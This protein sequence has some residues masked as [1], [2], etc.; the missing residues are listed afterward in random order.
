MRDTRL[1][2]GGSKC[3]R[4]LDKN[5]TDVNADTEPPAAALKVGPNAGKCDASAR[6]RQVSSCARIQAT[7]QSFSCVKGT[8]WERL[9]GDLTLGGFKCDCIH[10]CLEASDRQR[11]LD[12]FRRGTVP[13]LITTDFESR[14]LDVED[15]THVFNYD[16]PLNIGKYLHRVQRA[17]RA[18]RRGFS[19]TLVSR[20]EWMQTR[21]LIEVLEEANQY[22]PQELYAMADHFD[23][24]KKR[25][26]KETSTDCRR[27][28]SSDGD[29]WRK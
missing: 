9:T 17:G 3:D 14:A 15:L 5:F 19:V 2:D 23:A 4:R 11:A 29:Q 7:R 20:Q 16:Y 10:E 8:G 24:W 25:C 22:V 12:D 6:E 1:D 18:G 13:I 21:D 28:G 26:A 27:K